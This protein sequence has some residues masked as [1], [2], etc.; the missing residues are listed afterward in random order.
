MQNKLIIVFGILFF[1]AVGI[2][3]VTSIFFAARAVTGRV[4]IELIEKAKDTAEIIDGRIDSTFQFLEGLTHM[5]L[6][7]DDSAPLQERLKLLKQEVQAEELLHD[8]G[9]IDL[10]GIMTTIGGQRISVKDEQWFQSV[11]QIKRAITEP[12]ISLTDGELIITLAVPIYNNKNERIGV[13]TTVLLAKNLS[14]LID[15]IVI[16]ETGYCYIIG[17]T[18]N[19]IAFRDIKYVRDFYNTAEDAKINK[20]LM[21]LAEIEKKVLAENKPGWGEYE[22][23]GEKIIAGYTQIKSTGWG[24]LVRAPIHE[25]M[26]DVKILKILLY[27][28]GTGVLICT[29]IVTL[30]VSL[31]IT[32][33]IKTVAAA[34]KDI[35]EGEGDLTVRLPIR[36]NN[37][38]TDLSRYFNQ[39]IGK[40]NKSIGAV[41]YST[42][43]MRNVGN[44]LASNMTETASAVHQINANIE[45]VKQQTVTQAAS[46]SETAST[47]EEIIRTIKQLNGS[48]ENQAASVTESSAAIEQMVANIASITQTLQKTDERIKNLASATEEGRQTVVE[49]SSITQKIAEESGGLIEASNVIQHIAS[50]TNLLS[51]NAAIEAAHAGESGKGFAVVADEIR[52]LAEESSSQGKSITATLKVLSGEIETLSASAK[53]AEEKFNAIFS[54]SDEVKTMST[55]LTEAMQEQERGSKEV[56]AAIRD[57]NTVTTQV[58]E[59]SAEMLKGGE[60]AANE[61]HRLDDL[62]RVITN[63]MS[64]MAAGAMQINRAVE[65]VNEITQK[66]RQSIQDLSDEVKKFKI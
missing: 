54:I 42:D 36:G 59:G 47:M 14:D 35:A 32:T 56:L 18:G 52:K 40:I 65:E 26:N 12:A 30:L 9:I 55:R 46:V 61:M 24:L 33:P 20:T 53:T 62:T 27:I 8:A 34:L 64:E 3:T 48:I 23:N 21:P 31:K 57:I 66:N 25:F 45:G 44:E 1:L 49:S 58:K 4:E 28:L 5:P 10:Q 16:G 15:D 6:L 39:T 29:L 17:K 50:Q 22:W 60:N 41:N 2:L 38:M 13:L 63:S 19:H 43:I 37:E 11:L 51:M 7:R